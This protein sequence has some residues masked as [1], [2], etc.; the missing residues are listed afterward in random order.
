MESRTL[1]V[2]KRDVTFIM[3]ARRDGV[4]DKLLRKQQA[5]INARYDDDGRVVRFVDLRAQ[6]GDISIKALSRRHR[7]AVRRLRLLADN[8]TNRSIATTNDSVY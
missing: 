8:L 1:D 3:D 2:S 6:F 5:I 4:V 7:T